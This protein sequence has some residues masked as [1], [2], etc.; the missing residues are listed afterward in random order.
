MGK[1]FNRIRNVAR[2]LVACGML[3]YLWHMTDKLEELRAPQNEQVERESIPDVLK[4]ELW[5]GQDEEDKIELEVDGDSYHKLVNTPRSAMSQ[6]D[7]GK[8]SKSNGLL[9]DIAEG[10]MS[11]DTSNF[12]GLLSEPIEDDLR[13][14]YS[15]DNREADYTR[16]LDF[17]HANIGYEK[18]EGL[19]YAQFP[20]ETL[21]KGKGDCEDMAYLAAA[22]LRD[23]RKIGIVFEQGK[24]AD[25]ATIAIGLREGESPPE[26]II[27]DDGK[28]IETAMGMIKSGEL[29]EKIPYLESYDIVFGK[30]PELILR[31]EVPVIIEHSGDKYFLVETG[32][33]VYDIRTDIRPY[34]FHPLN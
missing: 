26:A 8:F 9:E 33:D 23:K 5:I 11:A 32:S 18:D 2:V 29:N 10:I 22:L 31:R 28:F 24:E 30:H 4:R 20:L 25:H 34:T 16:V 27:Y 14:Q 6:R 17:V 7:F 1:R 21:V 19:G 15:T 12:R 13:R 3:G